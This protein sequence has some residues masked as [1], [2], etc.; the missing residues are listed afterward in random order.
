[1]GSEPRRQGPRGP[2]AHDRLKAYVVGVVGHFKA[3]QRIHAWDL[4]NEP[5]NPN[6]SS[7]GKIELPN[8]AEAA[9]GF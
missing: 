1:M 5:D 4:F 6:R 9:L 7:Y 2:D 3:D 8:K